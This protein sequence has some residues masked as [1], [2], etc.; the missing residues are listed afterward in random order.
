MHQKQPPAKV[1]FSH[2][3]DGISAPFAEVVKTHNI[4]VIASEAKQSLKKD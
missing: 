3:L 2:V 1:A 4:V